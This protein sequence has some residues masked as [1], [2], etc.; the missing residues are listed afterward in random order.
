MQKGRRNVANEA[1]GGVEEDTGETEVW[2]YI[3]T[4]NEHIINTDL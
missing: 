4:T 1:G 2:H 3:N